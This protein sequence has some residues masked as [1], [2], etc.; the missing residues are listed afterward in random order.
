MEQESIITNDVEPFWLT[1]KDD[2][3]AEEDFIISLSEAPIEMTWEQ[4]ER[5]DKDGVL[6]VTIK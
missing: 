5:L 4:V 1:V 2:T 3:F 6:K